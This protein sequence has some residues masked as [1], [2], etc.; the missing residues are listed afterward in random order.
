MES[1]VDILD[2]IEIEWEEPILG[3]LS[4]IVGLKLL[5]G[6]L[7]GKCFKETLIKLKIRV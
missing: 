1:L 7:I 4:Q 6:G 2:R 5:E 3:K